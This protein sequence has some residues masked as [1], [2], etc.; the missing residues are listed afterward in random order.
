MFHFAFEYSFRA[1]EDAK[2]NS[3]SFYDQVVFEFLF[4]KQ[5]Q[6]VVADFDFLSQA[7]VEKLKQ[8]ISLTKTQMKTRT[9]KKYFDKSIL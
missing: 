1:Q 5:A 7:V 3:R 4:Q 8:K 6:V 2:I 9:I